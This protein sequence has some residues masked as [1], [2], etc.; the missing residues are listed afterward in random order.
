MRLLYFYV[1]FVYKLTD[2]VSGSLHVLFQLCVGL[3]S[4]I[5]AVILADKLKKTKNKI[6]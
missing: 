4:L 6:K 5:A 2:V 3:K 1:F